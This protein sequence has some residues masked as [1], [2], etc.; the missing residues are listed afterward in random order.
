MFS[1]FKAKTSFPIGEVLKVD[2]HSHILPGIDDGAANVEE[3]LQLIDGLIALGYQKLIATPHVMSDHHPN[4][5]E[6]IAAAKATLQAALDEKGYDISISYA[7]EYMLD[8]NFISLVESDKLLTLGDRWLLVETM[9]YDS[10]PNLTNILFELQT[11]GIRPILAH[12]ER[13]HYLDKKLSKLEVWKDRNCF[14]QANVLSF[15]GYYGK[16]EQENVFRILDAGLI[17]F[18]GT[19]MHHMR[20]LKHCQRLELPSKVVKKLEQIS[21]KNWLL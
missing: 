4:T 20:H 18:I 17:D 7:A 9:F 19:D 8:E 21:Y 1:I 13:Y 6:T 3:S 2:M 16:Q 5:P 10:P 14:L 12:P 15:A 11:R